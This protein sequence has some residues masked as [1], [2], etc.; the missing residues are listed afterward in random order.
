MST[1]LIK[2]ARVVAALCIKTSGWISASEYICKHI[3][4]I[5]SGCEECEARGNCSGHRWV[6][7]QEEQSKKRARELNLANS[8]SQVIRI[9]AASIYG[10]SPRQAAMFYS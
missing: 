2:T 8:I 9:T 10:A 5:L 6:R 7:N 3:D 1:G 4:S